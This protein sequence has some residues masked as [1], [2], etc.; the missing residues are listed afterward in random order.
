MIGGPQKSD[1]ALH[2]SGYDIYIMI[3]SN[4]QYAWY[5]NNVHY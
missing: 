3:L 2:V 4:L 1:D 5:S